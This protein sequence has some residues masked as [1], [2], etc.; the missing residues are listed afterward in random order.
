MVSGTFDFC[1][2]VPAADDDVSGALASHT[3]LLPIEQI[4]N[5]GL[6]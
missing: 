6:I 1:V 4:V 5:K 3:P 2:Y